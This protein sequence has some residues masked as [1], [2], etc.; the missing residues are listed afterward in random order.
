MSQIRKVFEPEYG[1]QSYS[2]ELHKM[3]KPQIININHS[4]KVKVNI[5]GSS[6]GTG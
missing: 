4:V 3:C 2:T 6:Q 5:T 1:V